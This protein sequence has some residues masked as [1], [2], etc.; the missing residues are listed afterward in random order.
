MYDMISWIIDAI[1]S[2]HDTQFRHTIL[3]PELIEHKSIHKSYTYIYMHTH[4]QIPITTHHHTIHD[5]RSIPWS[6]M[7]KHTQTC[8]WYNEMTSMHHMCVYIHI[9]DHT[10]SIEIIKSSKIISSLKFSENVI[11]I[12]SRF[13][14]FLEN[15]KN[16]RQGPR[17]GYWSVGSLQPK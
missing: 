2:M 15:I 17:P 7:C 4:P 13:L 1:T 10:K 8:A 6:Y 3:T 16:L 12:K 11:S 9:F 5:H 14:T